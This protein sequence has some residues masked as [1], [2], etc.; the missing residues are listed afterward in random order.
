MTPVAATSNSARVIY[1]HE[2]PVL[3]SI[4]HYVMISA[5]SRNGVHIG[6]QYT[7]VDQSTGREDEAPAPPVVAGIAQV[8]RVTPAA[9]TVIIVGHTQP[10]IREGMPVR[11]SGR[12]P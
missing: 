12:M 9:S 8:V 6:D 1:V 5:G 4:G 10:T 2:Q 11:L 7:F 3:P